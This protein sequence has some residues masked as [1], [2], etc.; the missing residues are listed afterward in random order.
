MSSAAASTGPT[1]PPETRQQAA[2]RHL[3]T[4][5]RRFVTGRIAHKI[6]VPYVILI[7]LLAILASYI[8]VHLIASSLEEKFQDELATAGRSANEAMVLLEDRHLTILRQ[9]IYTDGVA[10]ALATRDA[11]GLQS[12]LAP[13][14]A[15]SRIAYVDVFT[16][17]GRELLWLR[18]RDLG[19][20]ADVLRDPAA[21]QWD[22][23]RQVLGGRSDR[24]GDKFAGMVS[25]PAG[26]LLVS[27][28]P[29]LQDGELVGA[30]A[31][32][33]PI[34]E[35]ARRL[36]QEAGGKGIT[37]YG[38]DGVPITSTIRAT[39][40]EL[41]SA[42]QL[43]EQQI[44]A[45]LS[46]NK[47]VVRR[48]AIGDLLYLEALG[49]LAIRR[50]P[51]LVLGTG[52]LM[53]I[54]EERGA[55]SRTLM[56]GLFSVVLMLVFLIS[57]VLAR[58]LSRPVYTLLAATKRVQEND[59]DFE[60]P[61]ETE[62]EHG[63]LASAFNEMKVGLQERE[64]SRVAIERYMS[65]KVYRLIQTGELR[66][67]G[68]SREITVVKT[69]IRDFTRLSERMEPQALVHFLNRYFEA[70]VAPIS[71]YDG[72]VDKYMGDSV[73]AK[74]GATEWYPDHAR[75]AVL[76]MI[77]MIE[78][79]ERFSEEL[80]AEGMAPIRMGIG[81]NTGEAIVGNIGSSE[82][83]EYT[84]IS[85]AVN[86]A[87][88]I[89]EL[90]KEVGWDLLIS[91]R[92]WAAVKEIVEAGRPW[93]IRLRGHTRD[94]LVYPVLGQKGAVPL[95]RRRAYEALSAAGSS[96]ERTFT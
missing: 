5:V 49:T 61:I 92:T 52:N 36:S 35:V 47:V 41:V 91:D 84:I 31:V 44:A 51:A 62:D 18:S 88:R 89:E 39:G 27:A 37:L 93:K 81:A 33:T 94:T 50:Q 60:V 67:G 72:E 57:L 38:R 25:T 26:Y 68:E 17:E 20:N 30:I 32:G 28:A 42:L 16:P 90:C 22:P 71:K 8:T 13:I 14:A 74:F 11:A 96:L 43:P 24:F 34:E 77:E 9:M 45:A 6:T 4:S 46:G 54:I 65:P 79:C 23:V 53:S 95:E 48:A 29:V 78:A 80:R 58:R 21:G 40:S 2:Q 7:C 76:A 75:R 82:R 87:Q 59:L 66:M 15:N 56:T 86:T 3:V 70:L 83:M 55:Q 64:R 85:D 10:P 1:R 69:D 12:L 19:G 73:L 63:I